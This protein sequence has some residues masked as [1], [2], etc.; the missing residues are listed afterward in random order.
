[1]GGQH[2][3]GAVPEVVTGLLLE[4]RTLEPGRLVGEVEKDQYKD[5]GETLRHV[6]AG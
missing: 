4:A 5:A 6:G 3:A 1:M 2:L